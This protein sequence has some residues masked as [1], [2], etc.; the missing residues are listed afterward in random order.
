MSVFLRLLLVLVSLLHLS[1]SFTGPSLHCAV[2]REINPCTCKHKDA[3]TGDITV[4]CEKMTSFGQVVDA[5]Q[6]RFGNSKIA[7]RI[8]VSN[9]DDLATKSFHLLGMRIIHLKLVKN[10]LSVLPVDVF[11]GLESVRDFSISDNVLTDMPSHILN[12]MPSLH[13]LDLNRNKITSLKQHDLKGLPDLA[14]ILLA[15]NYLTQIDENSFPTTLRRVHI[16]HNNL[17]SLNNSIRGLTDLEWLFINNNRLTS[18]EG[19]LG[20]LRKLQLL[21]ANNNQLESLPSDIQLLSNMNTLVVTQ[22]K[23]NQLDNLL[24]GLSKLEKTNLENNS[25][26]MLRRDE[27]HGLHRL[28]ELILRNNEIKSINGSMS[29][30]INLTYLDLAHNQLPEFL[31]QDIIGPKR[32]RVLD[33]S[34]NK[35]KRLGSRNEDKNLIEGG[36]KIGELK[37]QHNEIEI[38]DGALMGIHGLTRLNLS[39][40]RLQAIAPDDFIGLDELKMLDLS[41]NLLSTLS[42]TSK[43][44]LPALEELMVS[45]NSLTALE[46][47]FHGLPVL[48]MADLAHNNIKAINIQLALKTQCK[49]YG[50]NSTLRI[51]LQG[52]PVLCEES[53]RIV[54]EAMEATNNTKIHAGETMCQPETVE[55]TSLSTTTTT[56]VTESPSTKP[57]PTQASP[58]TQSST[59][60]T[61]A[62]TRQT[63]STP[64]PAVE[65][66]TE[67]IT[68]E[69]PQPVEPNNQIPEIPEE[70]PLPKQEEPTPIDIEGHFDEKVMV[71]PV[72]TIEEEIKPIRSAL[73]DK[74]RE[75]SGNTSDERQGEKDKLVQQITVT[76]KVTKETKLDEV[77]KTP[78]R[79]PTSEPNSEPASKPG[80]SKLGPVLSSLGSD[81]VHI[82]YVVDNKTDMEVESIRVMNN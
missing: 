45:H 72:L 10:N 55:T 54:I 20:A 68:L 8:A 29:T 13:T 49:M 82:A 4:V 52:N 7:L 18:L 42:E 75:E 58:T 44:F 39:H 9:L 70:K 40:N 47:D 21:I 43:T 81:N 3:N 67:T 1:T 46:K 23:I 35:I 51:Y 80:V 79:I 28:D 15:D 63:P 65:E 61:P 69:F 60:S 30:L 77:D 24:S 57:T 59:T 25:I 53:M 27:F 76:G 34:H 41:H 36:I 14:T 19:E 26:K 64:A 6:D 22:N 78:N 38:L 37:L 33:L 48:C 66:I 73:S 11:S 71:K 50:L 16:G 2:R 5:L 74:R 62:T 12:R 31:V 56:T 17:T 32:L